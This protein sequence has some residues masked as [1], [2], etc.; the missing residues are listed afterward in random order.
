MPRPRDL[1][2][3]SA[4][5]MTTWAVWYTAV[6]ATNLTDLL[7]VWG[8]LSADFGWVSGNYAAFVGG[9]G[10]G[11][12]VIALY[13]AGYL[14]ELATTALFWR[15]LLGGLRAPE[16]M[17]ALARPAFTLGIGFWGAFIAVAELG[18]AGTQS[19]HLGLFTA[20]IASLVAVELLAQRRPT[21]G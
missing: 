5:I 2:T 18:A 14:W 10:G 9:A 1:F 4:A 3:P 15:A 20:S 7:R 17:A 21:A 13:L 8:V 6:V 12:G 19:I 11:A 16:R